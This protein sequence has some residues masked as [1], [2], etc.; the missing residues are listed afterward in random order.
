MMGIS[1]ISQL[2][3][4]VGEMTLGSLLGLTSLGL[5]T[6]ASSL[7]NTLYVNVYGAGSNV[8][9]SRLSSDLR[10]RGEFYDNYLR[11]MRLLL[12]FLWP[13]MFG[14][15]I[16]SQPIIFILYGAKWQ[17]AATP[18]SL[19]TIAAAIT[20]AIGMTAE[21]FILRHRTQQQV[22]IEVIRA[23]I[24]YA[25]FAA[26]AMISL[27]LAAGSKVVEAVFA[28]LLYRKPMAELVGGPPGALRRTYFEALLV[29]SVGVLPSFL[30]MIWSGWSPATPAVH[31]AIAALLGVISWAA[32]LV[33]LRHPL[34]LECA[35]FLRLR[36]DN[37]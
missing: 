32:L 11:F 5:F 27:T 1:G 12:G 23:V 14:I 24:G 19:L 22:R 3:G 16:L 10:E 21:I 4:R 25:A 7:P 35:R 31:L 34:Y 20:A 28:F 30:L 9:F 26:G 8:V 2:S 33:A 6:R 13:T 29:T 18:L 15:A 17:A 37:D 36:A